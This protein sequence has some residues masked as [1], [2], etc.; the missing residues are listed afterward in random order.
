MVNF[1]RT[2]LMEAWRDAARLLAI[3]VSEHSMEVLYLSMVV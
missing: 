3:I 2:L 1:S